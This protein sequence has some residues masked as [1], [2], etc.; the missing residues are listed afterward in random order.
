M[1]VDRRS[2]APDFK[3]LFESAPGLY[4]VLTPEF[5]IVAVSDAYLRATMTTREGILGRGIFDVFPDNPDDPAATGVRNLKA[6]LQ[7]VR[8]TSAPDT[9]AVQ[10]YD[11]RKP[12]A[13][14]GGFEER[15]WSPV[16]SPV[17]GPD[18]RLAYIIHR[19]EDVT[20]FVRLKQHGIEQ[21]KLTAE[22]RTKA[23]HMESE[24]F[25]RAQEVQE[26]NRRLETANRELAQ[27]YEKTR[28]LDR[29][30]T[31]F[32]STVSHELR[33]PLA[34][35]LGPVEKLLDGADLNPGQRRDLAV[36]ARNARTLLRHVNDLL[37]VAKLEAGKMDAIYSRAD[38]VHLV[39]TVASHFDSLARERG[40][41]FA[42]EAPATLPAEVDAEKTQRVVLNLVSN[43][44]K[45][46][47]AGGRIRAELEVEG[48]SACF[49]VA[50]SG[51]G[52]PPDLREVIFEPF[53][54]GEEG[55][56]RRFGG[57]GLGLA[58]AKEF[59]ELQG[60]SIA[61]GDAPEGGALF[62]ARLPLRAPA[63]A[64]VHA[65]ASDAE[66]PADYLRQTVEEQQAVPERP[67]RAGPDEGPL[68]LVVE[69]NPDMNRFIADTLGRHWRVACAHD[70]HE[71]LDRAVALH[72]D[73]VVSDVMMPGMS[74]DELL[75][76]LRLR[77]DLGGIP[78]LMLTARS[79]EASRINLLREGA[80]D[81]LTK[82]FVADELVARVANLIR[83]KQAR[84]A[85]AT[86]RGKLEQQLRQAQKMEA[87]GQLTGGLA[88]DFNNLLTVVIGN[89]DAL[90]ESFDRDPRA[91]RMADNA[92]QA[93]WRGAELTRQLLAFSRQQPLEPRLTDVN[94]LVTGMVR[95]L[96]RTL[97]EAVEI[98]FRPAPDL[99]P[100]TVDPAQLGS[101]IAN[102][103]TNARDA[104]PQGGKLVF[105]THNASLDAD[106]A[107]LN[108]EVVPGDYALLAVS[109]TGTGIPPEI[110]GRVFEPFFTTKPVGKGTGLGLSMVF[111]FIK[112]SGG[113]IK[114]YSEVGKGTIVRLYLPRARAERPATTARPPTAEADV[115]RGTETVLVVEDNP[116]VRLTVLRQ[117]Q[118]LGYRVLEADGADAALATL[119]GS[120]PVDL[121]FTDI[122]M[123]GGMNGR[124]LAHQAE[125]LRPGLKVLFTSGFMGT[126]LQDKL[127][128]RPRDTFLGKPYRRAELARK[129]REALGRK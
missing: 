96:G 57:T 43:A 44:F 101:A 20:D 89:L 59:V 63:G 126:G 113:H 102:L 3:A 81:Y 106:Y 27:L 17:L 41:A 92:L 66:L 37:D 85:E 74:G 11:I 4:L 116:G 88:H 21:D 108:P 82:P 90:V 61:V 112:Q 114:I 84:E 35:I 115:P 39:R 125:A 56:T 23:E 46:T 2:S 118:D 104:M 24:V 30:K 95:L 123:P 100:A 13:E 62:E 73:L 78:V 29:I 6:S 38:L 86:E 31:R 71:G 98:A 8:Q 75:R 19:V 32:F 110:L 36:V 15:Y 68:V 42:I 7:R 87:I 72:P 47:P 83:L 5:D 12:E 26:A 124:E 22:L 105:E 52:V 76:A 120:E 128:L 50:D 16:N 28:E 109:D 54:Q 117:L 77:D 48:E 69:D 53:R 64:P 40:I 119:L 94:D 67:A 25:L 79:D 9:M 45:F 18:G 10:K 111:G 49:G 33:T 60:G 55:A 91:K 93:A 127:Q 58:I 97:G 103:A 80:Q 14:G 129:L 34:L 65:P 70:G 99:W 121:L 1:Q 51:P 107:T 122:V